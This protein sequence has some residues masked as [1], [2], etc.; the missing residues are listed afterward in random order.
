M[1]EI[2]FNLLDEPWVR[3]LRPD[4]TVEEVSL[5]GALLRAQ[6]Y[7][8]LAGELPTQDAAMLR[9]LLAVLHSVFSRVDAEGRAAP[10]TGPDIPPG[11]A[12]ARWQSLWKQGRLPEQPLRAYFARWHDRFWLFH[13]D[14][15]FWQVPQAKAGI[16]FD[17]QKLNGEISQ[18]NH[19]VQLFSGFSGEAK[20]SLSYAQAARWLLYINGYDE[21]GGRPKAGNLPRHGVGWLGQ[22]G[23]TAVK[24]K[25]LF[26]T[27]MRNLVLLQDDEKP[28][29]EPK[30]L[31]EGA[32]A[33]DRQSWEIPVPDNQA[34]MLTLQSRRI[35]L[36]RKED[37][38]IGHTLLG[39]DYIHAENAF[40]EQMTIW[41]K[42]E[43][44]K[45]GLCSYYPAEHDPGKQMWRELPTFFEGREPGVVRWNMLLQRRRILDRKVPIFLWVVANRYDE[46]NRASVKD[47]YADAI[48]LHLEVLNSLG[49]KQKE[50]VDE[51]RRCEQAAEAVGLLAWRLAVA[52][53]R[54]EESGR[55]AVEAPARAQFYFE[56]DQPF[57]RWLYT[58]DP[59]WDGG[60]MEASLDGWQAQAQRLACALG[61]QMVR[62]AG[63]AAFAGR[64]VKKEKEQAHCSAP[65]A[66]NA[67][68]GRIRAIYPGKE[69]A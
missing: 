31:W 48:A 56:V 51:V 52:A 34:E 3:V 2:E 41:K 54:S 37:R 47:T 53:G 25:T 1:K 15:P 49:N 39:G 22:I 6:D 63:A 29:E 40:A 7:A 65:E 26:E 66:W 42:K 43:D 4:C 30:P 67:F 69:G 12:L 11:A 68:L 62:Q 59:G 44:K 32:P 60:E 10:I 64:M 14:R 33:G 38:V 21:R 9:L 16:D 20:E 57:R 28:W 24:G 46:P 55:S 8:D 35:I 5:A 23:F 45:T 19:K 50:V 36:K 61:A 17:A 13:P 27:L 58:L 18:S